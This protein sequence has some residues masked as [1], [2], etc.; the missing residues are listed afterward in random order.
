MRNVDSTVGTAIVA[1]N[2]AAGVRST[3][4]FEYPFVCNDS[5]RGDGAG[6]QTCNGGNHFE[7]GTG[8]FFLFQRTVNQR[9]VGIFQQLVIVAVVECV[10]QLVVVVRRVS[11]QRQHLTAVYFGNHHRPGRGVKG[12]I[13][14]AHFAAFQLTDDERGRRQRA[15]FHSFDFFRC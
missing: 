3:G 9:C 13:S 2:P 10:D 15:V 12:C 11:Y 8:R 14:G 1:V 5:G 7:C 4:V 6:F